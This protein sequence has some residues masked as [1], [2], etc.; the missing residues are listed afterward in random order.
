MRPILIV[1]YMRDPLDSTGFKE[2]ESGH[3]RRIG[4]APREVVFSH[5][6]GKIGILDSIDGKND[7]PVLLE[8]HLPAQGQSYFLALVRDMGVI[9]FNILVFY[10]KD[11]VVRGPILDGTARFK[12]PVPD[13]LHPIFIIR[14]HFEHDSIQPIRV[15]AT[16]SHIRLG[17]VRHVFQFRQ[18]DTAI[19]HRQDIFHGLPIVI[20]IK[21]KS[22]SF[23]ACIP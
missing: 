9:D 10:N 17:H 6:G 16:A 4:S 23:D 12:D 5:I 7:R 3:E 13:G 15:H 14:I 18:G 21:R 2:R 11:I 20:E 22:D 1:V 19:G 8:L